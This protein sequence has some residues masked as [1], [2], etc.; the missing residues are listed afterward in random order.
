MLNSADAAA[1]A[2]EA[3]GQV[4]LS[5]SVSSGGDHRTWWIGDHHVLR[6]APDPATSRRLDREVIVRRWL[7]QHLRSPVPQAIAQGTWSGTSWV[8]DE[9]LTGHGLEE[10]TI[11]S[12]TLADLIELL[13]DLRRCPPAEAPVGLPRL[14]LPDLPHL[15][16]AALAAH[17]ALGISRR[18]APPPGPHV[19]AQGSVDHP[20][21]VHAD[22]KGEHLLIDGAGAL[23]GVLDWSDA[24]TGDASL[25]VEGLIVAIGATRATQVATTAGIP[26]GAV[27]RGVF[28]ARCRTAL[29]LDALVNRGEPAGPEPLL[30][31]QHHLAWN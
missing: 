9:R 24:G 28:L 25:D 4:V 30:R 7:R 3:L 20:V 21:L 10:G 15:A 18:L 16:D 12:R 2:T 26:A 23:T 19:D 22:L 11:T 29:R 1:L 13:A 6:W 27:H 17:R 31:H 8:L 5:R 14:P